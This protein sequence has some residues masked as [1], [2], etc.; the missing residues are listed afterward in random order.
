VDV[1]EKTI[2][3]LVDAV[4]QVTSSL[5][6]GQVLDTIL[7]TL[8]E[9]IDYQ[10]A[11]VCVVDSKTRAV[12]D[13]KSRGYPPHPADRNFLEPGAG[14]IGWV[15]HNAQ[16]QIVHDVKADTRYVKARAETRS[17]I[18]AP[19]IRT[20]GEVIGAINL[21][22]DKPDSYG[23]D[24]LE[25]LTMFA[26]LAASAIN[27]TLLYREVLHSRRVESEL[28]LAR[29][30]VESLLPRAFPLIEGFDIY[31]STIPVRQ[32]GGD[33]F[34]FISSISYR[35][36]V[37]VADVSGK[38]LPAALVMVSFRAYL[39]ATIINDLSM[40]VVMSRVN[41][42]VYDSTSGDRFI[43]TFYGLIDPEHRRLLYINA[44][45]NPP[46]LLHADGTS[47]LLTDGG[48]PLGVFNDARYSESVVNF[49]PGDILVLYT[50]GV[51]DAR[52]GHEESF[53]VERLE[54]TVRSVAER[55]AHEICDAVTTAV[56]AHSADVGGL[57]DDLTVSV[58]K[59]K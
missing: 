40:R 31:G 22:S 28:E 53:G 9:L 42:L 11:V 8:K 23:P 49:R 39:L 6:L 26:S 48:L 18:A 44:G 57:E 2:N 55:R 27:N 1:S 12:R 3:T 19:I 21:E 36:A 54:R 47:E 4:R 50:D 33:Y 17:E 43:T 38:G 5:N 30:V 46:L 15:V 51:T 45:H 14:I 20:D 41:R 16:G 58:I 7:D 32:V 52:N 35:L 37:L 10:A 13:L 34:D 25:L 59:V 29:T 56:R 24:H